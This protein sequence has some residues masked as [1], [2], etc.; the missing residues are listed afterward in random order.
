METMLLLGIFAGLG[1]LAYRLIRRRRPKKSL[2]TDGTGWWYLKAGKAIGPV[3]IDTLREILIRN[4]DAATTQV[5]R[6]G[7]EDWAL[8]REVPS[9]MGAAERPPPIITTPSDPKPAI[10]AFTALAVGVVIMAICSK[11]IY[12]NSASGIGHL[13]G[14]FIG[15]AFLLFL[16]RLA[17]IR[18]RTKYSDAA[19]F[20]IAAL[21]VAGMNASKGLEFKEA[22][23]ALRDVSFQAKPVADVAQQHTSNKFLQFAALAL[24]AAEEASASAKTV[25]DE[26]EPPLLA[27]DIN[28]TTATRTELQAYLAALRT[29]QANATQIVPRVRAIEAQ[30]HEKVKALAK[31]TGVSDDVQSNFLVG[32]DEAAA[33]NLER[34][35]RQSASYANLYRALAAN[36]T[37]L[38][39]QYG[40]YQVLP[41]KRIQFAD[42]TATGAYSVNSHAAEAAAKE[43]QRLFE[44]AQ[45]MQR[46][47]RTSFASP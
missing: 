24:S 11:I 12:D 35:E 1:W 33:K 2:G 28:P 46:M 38:I 22:K 42:S 15:G 17:L 4:P 10:A 9:L 43:A 18:R 26:L 31:T 19:I 32:L 47:Q 8:A 7:V 20:V 14:E 27:K 3:T 40:R 29:A 13:T 23:E 44:E 36:C 25:Y 39:E 16:L 5:W 21:W 41:D 30:K 6:S 34:L 37:L 45:Q